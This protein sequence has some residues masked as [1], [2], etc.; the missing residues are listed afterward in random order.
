MTVRIVVTNIETNETAETQGEYLVAVVAS[1]PDVRTKRAN[2]NTLVYGK[3]PDQVEGMLTN[4]LV[5]VVRYAEQTLG[6]LGFRELFLRA[7]EQETKM[8]NA[9]IRA[10]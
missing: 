7:I 10:G 1:A 3:E 5:S 8:L 9:Y 4:L 2:I 6:F